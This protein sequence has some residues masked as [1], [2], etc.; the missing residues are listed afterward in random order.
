MTSAKIR[1]IQNIYEKKY[2][3]LGRIAGRYVGAG[4]GVEF[5]HP[6]RYGPVSLLVRGRGSIM[7]IEVVEN[8]DKVD[9]EK[10]KVFIEKAKLLKA[11]PVLILYSTGS[12]LSDD[13]RKLCMDNGVKIRRIK[14]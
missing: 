3:R 7:A 1:Y 13:V 6:T 8:N 5:N 12:K 11:K 4:Y 14:L 10:I 9:I 2:G